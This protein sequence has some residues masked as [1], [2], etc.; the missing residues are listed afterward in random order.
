VNLLRL[1]RRLDQAVQVLKV[2]LCGAQVVLD[3][4]LH[5]LLQPS[6]AQESVQV[7]YCPAALN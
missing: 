4:F 5:G 2:V 7:F 6:D 1:D 3:D